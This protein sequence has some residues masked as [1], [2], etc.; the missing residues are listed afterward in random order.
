M[1]EFLELKLENAS[2]DEIAELLGI[3]GN[4]FSFNSA[5]KNAPYKSPL[6]RDLIRRIP[7]QLKSTLPLVL[8]S[9][10][11]SKFTG[12]GDIGGLTV[13]EKMFLLPLFLND[14]EACSDLIHK[15]LLKIWSLG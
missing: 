5:S 3:D 8:R 10:V 7:T 1:S 2:F 12:Y 14:I 6:I 13:D 4:L 15:D 11:R 9:F